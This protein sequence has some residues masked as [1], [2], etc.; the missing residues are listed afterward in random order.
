MR[1]SGRISAFGLGANGQLGVGSKDPHR[2]SPSV[3]KGPF[4]P[5]NDTKLS[6]SRPNSGQY[7][8]KEIFAG[9]DQSFVI[10]MSPMVRFIFLMYKH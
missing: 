1:S 4:L 5:A 9:G 7:I 8:V 3:V 2:I 10:S 6:G